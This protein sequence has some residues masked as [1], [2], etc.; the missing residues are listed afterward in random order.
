MLRRLRA[1]PAKKWSAGISNLCLADVGVSQHHSRLK[2]HGSHSL[3][4]SLASDSA[5]GTL[6]LQGLVS[7]RRIVDALQ[8]SP[9]DG[10]TL[11]RLG[12]LKDLRDS[13]NAL[14]NTISIFI[15]PQLLAGVCTRPIPQGGLHPRNICTRSYPGLPRSACSVTLVCVSHTNHITE[16]CP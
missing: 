6:Q 8:Q 12:A 11:L 13:R 15:N 2:P 16:V 14:S 4:K 10:V 5:P 9:S 7:C 1:T 3:V